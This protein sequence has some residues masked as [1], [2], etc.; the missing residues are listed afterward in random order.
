MLQIAFNTNSLSMRPNGCKLTLRLDDNKK[1]SNLHNILESIQ[2]NLESIQSNL[3]QQLTRK[4][5][6]K[7]VKCK[8]G[9]SPHFSLNMYN[10]KILIFDQHKKVHKLPNIISKLKKGVF[11]KVIFK[12]HIDH[13]EAYCGRN[14][15]VQGYYVKTDLKQL[16]FFQNPQVEHSRYNAPWHSLENYAFNSDSDEEGY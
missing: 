4:P 16:Q 10:S 9:Y 3:Q 6:W 1:S 14:G 11:V 5:I 7:I 15:Y 8:D 12:I 13:M 2:S